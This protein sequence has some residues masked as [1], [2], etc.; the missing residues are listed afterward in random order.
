[1]NIIFCTGSDFISTGAD[2]MLR[3]NIQRLKSFFDEIILLAD[4]GFL[5]N[6]L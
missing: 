5:K 2:E 6:L 4:A 3:Y 1:L